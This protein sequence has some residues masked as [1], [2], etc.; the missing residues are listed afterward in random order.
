MAKTKKTEIKQKVYVKFEDR[1]PGWQYHSW[2]EGDVAF[3]E[4]EMAKYNADLEAHELK[5]VELEK[6]EYQRQRA[7][8][9]PAIEEQLDIIYHNG[10]E[11]WKETIAAI[12]AEYPKPKN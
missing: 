7:A 11:A 1:L 10:I 5:I 9:Y 6:T 2:P 3:T 8:A 4:D 12:K